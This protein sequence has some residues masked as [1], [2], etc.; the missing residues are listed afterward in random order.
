M[1]IALAE[2]EFFHYTS[3][4]GLL[5]IL[6]TRALW[7][8]SVHYLNDEQ[9]YR[10]GH[11]IVLRHIENW[12]SNDAESQNLLS[13]LGERLKAWSRPDTYV[14]SFSS[15]PDLLS[16]WRAYCPDGSGVS[17]GFPKSLIER[18]AGALGF[19]F[20]PCIYDHT[21]QA[22]TVAAVLQ[23]VVAAW[24]QSNKGDPVLDQATERFL[25]LIPR[26]K[27]RS[28]AQEQEWRLISRPLVGARTRSS[29]HATRT[30][31]IPYFSLSLADE[32]EPIG[33]SNI[34][35]GP[36]HHI[37]AAMHAV[38]SLLSSAGDI[39]HLSVTRSDVPY[40]TW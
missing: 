17:I 1:A 3:F 21:S 25:R 38:S 8:T 22:Q 14:F 31:L 27:H 37:E 13:R 39:T 24:E 18:R 16:Q 11:E 5:G 34:Y 36:N 10:H 12:L 19:D 35:V 28:F 7:A 26:M 9:E 32:G 33:L 40:R 4:A 29:Y 2:P 15:V 6:Q 23:A 20:L 30:M